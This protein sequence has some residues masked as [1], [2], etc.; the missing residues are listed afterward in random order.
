MTIGQ[1]LSDGLKQK[2]KGKKPSEI[3]ALFKIKLIDERPIDRPDLVRMSE[4]RKNT[5]TIVVFHREQREKAIA[6]ELF[7]Y[8]EDMM[9]LELKKDE[10]E[11]EAGVFASNLIQ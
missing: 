4:Y 2:H 6:H 5:G 8:L 3:A 10:S 1:F 11:R 7:H 9:S